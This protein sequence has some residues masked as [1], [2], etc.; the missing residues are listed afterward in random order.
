MP[1][2]A[3][4]PVYVAEGDLRF[5]LAFGP[6]PEKRRSATQTLGAF[7]SIFAP[8]S[9]PTIE[10]RSYRSGVRDVPYATIVR[11]HTS[12]DGVTGDVLVV[13]KVD[14]DN[15]C[16]AAY[17]D[18]IANADA[19]ALAREWADKHAPEHKCDADPVVLGNTGKS[20]M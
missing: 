4:Y 10:W 7:N 9:R 8:R 13:T 2:T 11:Y 15:S 12:R 17:V 18:A 1:G 14:R 19:I 16:H 6:A 5:M 20:P 3:G